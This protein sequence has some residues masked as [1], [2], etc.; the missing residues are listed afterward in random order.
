[1]DDT[2]AARFTLEAKS[3]GT[4]QV[5]FKLPSYL[6]HPDWV[7]LWIANA[8][9][10]DPVTPVYHYDFPTEDSDDDANA[11]PIPAESFQGY[12]ISRPPL[13]SPSIPNHPRPPRAQ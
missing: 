5:N 6:A 4:Y 9:S 10:N 3:A 8:K 2:A 13:T 1:A 7:E 11:G 12:S